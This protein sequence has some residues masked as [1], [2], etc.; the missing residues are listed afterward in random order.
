MLNKPVAQLSVQELMAVLQPLEKKIDN[1]EHSVNKRIKSIEMRN[2]V[3]E[4]ELHQQKKKSDVLSGI[5]VDMQRALNNIDSEERSKNIIVSGISEKH[6]TIP[7]EPVLKTDQEK[8]NYVFEKINI[9]NIDVNDLRFERIGKE[10]DDRARM[11]KISFNDKAERETV[12]T[13]A[14]ELRNLDEPL[15]RVFIN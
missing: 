7:N 9:N 13:K 1:L 8:M 12:V 5:I 15:K 4:R 6:I 11:L 2:D 3:L 14:P 10:V